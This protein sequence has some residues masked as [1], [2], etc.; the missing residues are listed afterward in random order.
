[1]HHIIYLSQA[2]HS[3]S[4]EQLQKILLQARRYNAERNI[5]GLLLYGNGHFLQV[6]EGEQQTVTALYEKIKR[7]ARHGSV[8]T[9]ANKA[10]E[11][12]TFAEW[13]MAFK[14]ASAEQFAYL[15]DF[16]PLTPFAADQPHMTTV[17]A[18][19]LQTLQA[20]VLP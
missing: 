9:F 15:M 20:F 14:P 18:R 19:L 3:L 10:I 2:T 8:I 5:T 16:A 13:S 1:M 7:D 11:Q 17:D 12:R 4:D 6:I